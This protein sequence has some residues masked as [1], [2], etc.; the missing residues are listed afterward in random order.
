MSSKSRISALLAL[1]MEDARAEETAG[2]GANADAA[3]EAAAAA[4]VTATAT[5]EVPAIADPD[6]LEA[7]ISDINASE[8]DVQTSTDAV[9]ELEDVH[10][11]LEA[12]VQSIESTLSEGGLTPQSA[13]MMKIAY[14]SYANRLGEES[15]IPSMES[16]G[17]QTSR[18][19]QTTVSLESVRETLARVWEAIK[20]IVL[21]IRDW[22]I[23]FFKQ[24]ISGAE[25]LRQRATKV[26]AASAKTSGEAK[27]A[28]IDLGSNAAKIAIG[29]KV[30]VSTGAISKLVEI[31]ESVLT[32][33]ESAS[34]TLVADF[35]KLRQAA[36]SGERVQSAGE[37][38][39][40]KVF[41]KTLPDG[42]STELLPG[43]VTFSIV[44]NPGS[45]K[46]PAG[47]NKYLAGGWSVMRETGK[48]AVSNSK[49]KT[50]DPATIGHIAD[51]CLKLADVCDK[52]NKLIN[53]NGKATAS[54]LKKLVISKEVA[55]DKVAGVKA[56][57]KAFQRR[58]SAQDQAS[59]KVL[60]YAV[61]AARA[62]LA[63][64]EKS[65][66]Q[67]GNSTAVAKAA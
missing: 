22:I 23:A 28:E 36:N 46:L 32:F 21:K 60:A 57:M 65:L 38:Q 31:A 9:C 3:A 24:L 35:E 56:D 5:E 16:F 7:D 61:T 8:A 52:G 51:E 67:Y 43:N 41:S 29:P 17:G 25:K 53:E 47:V 33:D 59:T 1:S 19:D 2:D 39:P 34:K 12:L 42:V 30:D 45:D 44:I 49:V 15:T 6:T 63:A 64:A 37:L 18:L 14:E 10:E 26:K 11:G 20:S 40:P 48:D 62:Y 27:E 13:G 58:A 55:A 50:L 66:N 4:A 54:G